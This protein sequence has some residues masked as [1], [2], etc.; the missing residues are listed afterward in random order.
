M[1][2]RETAA[3]DVARRFALVALGMTFFALALLA[4]P[5]QASA[6]GL[7]PCPPGSTQVLPPGHTQ[8]RPV[9]EEPAAQLTVHSSPSGIEG[10]TVSA[11]SPYYP[12][13][14]QLRG[15]R[16]CA[17]ESETSAGTWEVKQFCQTVHCIHWHLQVVGGKPVPATAVV[18]PPP[19]A[20]SSFFH[21]WDA[22]CTPSK[23]PAV[24]RLACSVL[25]DVDRTVTGT[26]GTSAD[27]SPPSQPA[28]EL[29]KRL[30][31]NLDFRIKTPSTDD[32]WVGGYEVYGNDVLLTR[33]R[34]G[35]QV[36]RVP[37]LIC[38]K[39]Y[40][41]R[42]EAFDSQAATASET[43]S[44][45]TRACLRIPPNGYFHL[46]PPRQTRK[47]S[48]AFHWGAKRN[49]KE[50]TNPWAFKSR[51]RLDKGLWR[52]CSSVNGKVVRNLK[53]GWHTFRVRVGDGQG[54][55][56]TPAVWRWRVLR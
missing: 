39:S 46:K 47:K 12:S 35:Q 22:G 49:G 17:T 26:I 29:V 54:W 15:P 28:I 36:F 5:S 52:R 55:D 48:A 27:S 9:C 34:L 40:R 21:G 33:V 51:C 42:I 31:Q 45:K 13:E 1:R 23:R 3:S 30:R 6:Q 53:P 19:D 20:A 24:S 14:Y 7:P 10:F 44:A 18:T 43:I 2:E 8:C 37:N 50:I 16:E 41:W 25:V 4:W 32:I 56:P 11:W 38:N